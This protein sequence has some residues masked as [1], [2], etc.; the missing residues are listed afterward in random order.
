METTM[1]A[2]VILTREKML[3]EQE[4]STYA[5]EATSTLAGHEVSVLAFDGPHEHLE[6]PPTQGTVILEFPSIEAAK[7]WYNSPPHRRVRE[8][9]FRGTTYRVTLAAGV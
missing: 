6:G 5:K 7:V 9:R 2:Y 4:M 1:N 3:D 8:H